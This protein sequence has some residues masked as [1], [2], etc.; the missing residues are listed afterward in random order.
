MEI[1]KIDL[2][3]KNELKVCP[4]CGYSDGFHVMF[5]KTHDNLFEIR[6]IC[7]SCHKVFDIGW[8]NPLPS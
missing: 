1:E 8:H 4:E 3:G 7:P 6:L 5:K 2:K